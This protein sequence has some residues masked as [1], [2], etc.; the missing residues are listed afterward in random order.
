VLL[1]R[2]CAALT[3][4]VLTFGSLTACSR[5][6]RG[7]PCKEESDCEEGLECLRGH[8]GDAA[9]CTTRCES[10]DSCPEGYKCVELEHFSGLNACFEK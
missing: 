5:A 10:D 2:A 6:K 1:N 7:A 9:H 4:L 8:P 3:L